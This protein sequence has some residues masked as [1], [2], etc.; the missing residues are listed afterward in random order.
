MKFITIDD[1]KVQ[2]NSYI[3]VGDNSRAVLIDAGSDIDRYLAAEKEGGFVIEYVLLTHGHFDHAWACALLQA[4]GKK[5]GVSRADERLI[6]DKAH[7][8]FYG[9]GFKQLAAD[10]YIEDGEKLSL[11]G[12]SL[13]AIATPGHTAGG[14]CFLWEDKLFT[15]DTLFFEDVGRT[16]LFSGDFSALSAS[17]KD[18][19]YTLP[20]DTTV[21]PGH[22][23][24]T[25]IGYERTNNNYIRV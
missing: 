20:N 16:D 11:C 21:Y 3:L 6:K 8:P 2:S 12:F 19:L 7:I 9:G 23:Q 22:G 13:A 4:A 1:G 15:G 24:S 5:I 14:L 18:K 10:F 25:T 17:V